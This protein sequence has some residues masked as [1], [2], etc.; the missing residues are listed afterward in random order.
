MKSLF[1]FLCLTFRNM[2]NKFN[3]IS[4]L[5]SYESPIPIFRY[6]P[7][8][9]NFVLPPTENCYDSQKPWTNE[10]RPKRIKAHLP[11]LTPHP[12]PD[13]KEFINTIYFIKEDINST[14]QDKEL[15]FWAK[16]YIT[17]FRKFPPISDKVS[18]K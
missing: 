12:S 7:L 18:L 15:S 5:R 10:I 14:W 4:E 2:G 16:I 17:K 9:S 8:I 1:F 6:I 13:W 3:W 11:L